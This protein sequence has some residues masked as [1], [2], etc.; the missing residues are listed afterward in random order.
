MSSYF[1]GVTVVTAID[2]NGRP[3]GMTCSSLTSVTLT[4]PT[5]QVCLDVRS[6]TLAALR[7]QGTFAVNLLHEGSREAAETFASARPDRFEL[8]TWRPSKRHGLPW[9]CDDSYAMAECRVVDTLT[10]GDHV[11]VFGRPV[12]VENGV[13]RPLLYGRRGFTGVPA[14]AIA[15]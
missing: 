1:T 9:L 5:L 4:P 11:A 7:E 10:V 14:D 6:G 15:S 13:G 3:H 2:G 8:V 12:G